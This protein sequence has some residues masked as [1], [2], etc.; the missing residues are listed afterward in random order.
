MLRDNTL[1]YP[2]SPIGVGGSWRVTSQHV[3]SGI[4][5]KR[6]TTYRLTSVG[7]SSAT[8]DAHTVMEAAPQ[9]LSV[10]PNVT[11]R[12]SSAKGTT[13]AEH[14]VRLDVPVATGSSQGNLEINL[15]VVQGRLRIVS[16]IR[17]ETK[18]SVAVAK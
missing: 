5:W 17:S 1:I 12:I 15:L 6:T 14:E 7:D 10:E 9:A 13:N 11:A 16:S 3:A 2:D 18:I 8:I 4:T